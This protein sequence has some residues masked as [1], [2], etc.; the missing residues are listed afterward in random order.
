MRDVVIMMREIFV[1]WAVLIVL[2]CATQGSGD[3]IVSTKI[4]VQG[5]LVRSFEVPGVYNFVSGSGTQFSELDTISNATN[6]DAV[7]RYTLDGEQDLTNT[8]VWQSNSDHFRYQLRSW[9]ASQTE[10]GGTTEIDWET[11][12]HRAENAIRGQDGQIIESVLSLR[13]H[14]LDQYV[15]MNGTY[16]SKSLFEHVPGEDLPDDWLAFCDEKQKEMAEELVA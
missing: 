7:W 14:G 2:S 9:G 12:Y 15:A 16:A 5:D 11:G 6:T 4:Q 8:V 1:A 10:V 3:M 13:K